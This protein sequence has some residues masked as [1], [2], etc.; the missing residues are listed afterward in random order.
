[1]EYTITVTKEV[2]HVKYQ[3][4][5]ERIN[6][7]VKSLVNISTNEKV[8]AG[9]IDFKNETNKFKQAIK[10]ALATYKQTC[11]IEVNET[12]T[13]EQI[14]TM[15]ATLD[16]LKIQRDALLADPDIT[17]IETNDAFIKI[18]AEIARLKDIRDKLVLAGWTA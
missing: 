15:M 5:N 7:L 13:D 9:A 18:K 12:Y 3:V 11:L 4:A 2:N 17:D 6:E 14:T 1:M 16:A 10:N 8:S